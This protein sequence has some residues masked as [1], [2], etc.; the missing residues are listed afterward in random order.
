M[1]CSCIALIHCHFLAENKKKKKKEI[2]SKSNTAKY[3]RVLSYHM[4]KID[5]NV[6]FFVF[7]I[8]TV[9]YPIYALCGSVYQELM[10]QCFVISHGKKKKKKKKKK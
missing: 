6:D 9:F 10:Y 1:F 2:A 3:V 8:I 5:T 7:R 4:V